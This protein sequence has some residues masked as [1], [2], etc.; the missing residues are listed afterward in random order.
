[1]IEVSATHV[2]PLRLRLIEKPSPLHPDF[3]A[4]SYYLGIDHER[5]PVLSCISYLGHDLGHAKRKFERHVD[6]E[7]AKMKECES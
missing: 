2:G 1:M 7:T 4:P 5:A 3:F 6:L